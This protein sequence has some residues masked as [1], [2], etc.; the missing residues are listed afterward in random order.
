MLESF[1]VSQVFA[2]FLIFCRIGSGIMLLPGFGESYVSPLIRLMLA[3][4]VALLLTPVLGKSLPPLPSSPLALFLLVTCEI[5]TGL[6][7]G[8]ICNIIIS[9][10]HVAGMIF[11]AQSGLSSVVIFDVTQNSQGS[12]VGNFIGLLALLL[13]FATGMHHFMLRGITESYT[14]FVPG[15]FVPLASFVEIATH[16]VSDTFRVAVEIS[17]PLI[18]AGTLLFLSAGILSRLSP[19]MQV[20]F[21]VMPLQMLLGLFVFMT[22]F[23]A[24]MLWYME[25]Y[26]EQLTHFLGY[27]K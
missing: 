4:M 27:V 21:V 25:F 13:I 7:I 26:R 8:A 12:I 22:S 23:S 20:F 19:A 14:V 2:L 3:L 1:V 16:L 11:S 9:A 17:A 18:A 24:I 10:T 5:L 15:H 6:L